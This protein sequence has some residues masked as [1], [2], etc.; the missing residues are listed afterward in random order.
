MVKVSSEI[1]FPGGFCLI[2]ARIW[3]KST[4]TEVGISVPDP[5]TAYQP[6]DPSG[7]PVVGEGTENFIQVTRAQLHDILWGLKSVSVEY[8]GPENSPQVEAVCETAGVT[9]SS[10]TG[11]SPI[12]REGATEQSPAQRTCDGSSGVTTKLDTPAESGGV[13][14]GTENGMDYTRPADPYLAALFDAYNETKPIVSEGFDSQPIG[15]DGSASVEVRTET[16]FFTGVGEYPALI[17]VGSEW[18]LDSPTF[19]GSFEQTILPVEHALSLNVFFVPSAHTLSGHEEYYIK[20]PDFPWTTS[21]GPWGF[22]AGWMIWVLAFGGYTIPPAP[23]SGDPPDEGSGQVDIMTFIPYGPPLYQTNTYPA[24]LNGVVRVRLTPTGPWQTFNYPIF[25]L[26]IPQST[27]IPIQNISVGNI[28]DGP[29]E[30]SWNWPNDPLFRI[31]VTY[32]DYFA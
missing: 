8:K 1:P 32:T 23:G 9:I 10:I 26:V 31:S 21:L 27:G 16:Q 13:A 17:L 14:A 7:L 6:S 15:E 5:T 19:G 2:E 11:R 12:T 30:V 22:N 24:P 18:M 20:M 4:F 28:T 29:V 3:D 25:Q